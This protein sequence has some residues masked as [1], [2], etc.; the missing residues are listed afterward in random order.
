MST[1]AKFTVRRDKLHT[2]QPKQYN[3][4]HGYTLVSEQ[5]LLPA[6]TLKWRLYQAVK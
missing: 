1:G 4:M 3:T 5:Q 2:R 6:W